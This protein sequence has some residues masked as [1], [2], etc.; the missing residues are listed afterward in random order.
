[1]QWNYIPP[2]KI[3]GKHISRAPSIAGPRGRHWCPA[4][5]LPPQQITKR[6]RSSSI[7][8]PGLGDNALA[9]SLAPKACGQHRVRGDL[10]AGLKGEGSSVWRLEAGRALAR[11]GRP[12]AARAERVWRCARGASRRDWR[13][14]RAQGEAAAGQPGGIGSDGMGR[15]A[16]ACAQ[17]SRE[18]IA[19]APRKL[20]ANNFSLSRVYLL[21]DYCCCTRS[22]QSSYFSCVLLSPSCD[23]SSHKCPREVVCA[24]ASVRQWEFS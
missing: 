8:C 18:L 12:T 15:R 14:K 13:Q 7:V 17:S 24:L 9:E 6:R 22:A 3:Q 11:T 16:H 23:I 20:N 19:R 10:G 2:A 1:M 5:P 4:A 21:F